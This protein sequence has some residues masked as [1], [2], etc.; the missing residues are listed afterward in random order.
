MQKIAGEF[1]LVKDFFSG[2]DV[3]FTGKGR[4]SYDRVIRVIKGWYIRSH[5]K[6]PWK[7]VICLTK[8]ERSGTTGWGVELSPLFSTGPAAKFFQTA[9]DHVNGPRFNGLQRVL[10]WLLVIWPNHGCA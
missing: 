4:K 2:T 9:N 3:T 10:K 5:F 7:L 6:T 1:S 8:P